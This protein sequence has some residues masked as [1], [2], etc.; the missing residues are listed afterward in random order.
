MISRRE[1]EKIGLSPG[2]L[3]CLGDKRDKPI[4]I[5]VIDLFP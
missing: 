4:R 3:V 5:T 2:T 1:S